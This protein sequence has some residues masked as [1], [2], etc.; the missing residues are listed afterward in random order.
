MG[1]TTCMERTVMNDSRIT[2]SQ[3]AAR[4]AVAGVAALAL[5]AGAAWHG[6]AADQHETAKAAAT[7]TTPITRAIAGGR[8]SYADIVDVA[9]PAVVTIRTAGRAK[10]QPTEFQGQDDE[11]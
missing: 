5:V 11:F 3:R 9:A 7:V 10:I 1:K 2:L 8:D 4:T 6:L